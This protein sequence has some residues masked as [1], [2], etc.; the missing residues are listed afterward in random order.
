MSEQHRFWGRKIKFV[1]DDVLGVPK[2]RTVIEYFPQCE[3]RAILVGEDIIL[4]PKTGRR[5]ADPYGCVEN[6]RITP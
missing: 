3:T 6:E 1:G 5:G 2:N 4:P